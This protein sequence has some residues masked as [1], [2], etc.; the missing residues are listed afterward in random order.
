MAMNEQRKTWGVIRRIYFI[1]GILIAIPA[2]LSFASPGSISPFLYAGV[3]LLILGVA[4]LASDEL[5]Q[6]I[7]RI[8]WRR[9]WPK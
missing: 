6:R 8:Y 5:L 9:E 7:H 2:G 3:A 4:L 1:A